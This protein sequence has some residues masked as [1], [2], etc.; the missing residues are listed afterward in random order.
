MFDTCFALAKQQPGRSSGIHAE[1]S[2]F[3]VFRD[4]LSR[5]MENQP[6]KRMEEDMKTRT[7]CQGLGGI[8]WRVRNPPCCEITVWVKLGCT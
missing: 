4:V 1:K 5:V 3:R 7:I 6:D 2:A 8:L